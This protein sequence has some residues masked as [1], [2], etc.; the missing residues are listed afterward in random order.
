[1]R[2]GVHS[3]ECDICSAPSDSCKE[4]MYRRWDLGCTVLHR[5]S[6]PHP[7]L[8][9]LGLFPERRRRHCKSQG[10]WRTTANQCFPGITGLLHTPTHCGGDEDQSRPICHM[11]EPGADEAPPT[12]Y[13]LLMTEGRKSH[14][15]SR[16]EALVAFPCYGRWPHTLAQLSTLCGLSGLKM[17]GKKREE[18]IKSVR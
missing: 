4:P 14:F 6:V 18:T 9:A 10:L 2:L 3:T 7:L 16:V 15:L 12:C 1:M 11:D 5:T 17:W 8:K 13:W